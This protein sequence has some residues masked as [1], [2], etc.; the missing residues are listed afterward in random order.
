MDAKITRQ[1]NFER[2]VE[3]DVPESELTPHFDKAYQKYKK[4][5][6]LEGFRKGK[7]PMG[8]VKQLY[9]DAIKGETIDDVV[10]SVFQEVRIK[11]GLRPVAPAKLE[12][13]DYSPE[14]GLHFK[15]VV[16]VVPEIEL[17]NYTGLSVER[18][19]YQV[20]DK[21]VEQALE[22]YRER[23]ATM[24]PVEGAAA[25]GHF[26]VVD[27]QQVDA[28]GVP[29]IGKKFDDRLIELS[30]REQS[31]EMT[32]QLVG[33]KAGET[34]RVE[35]D[36]Y[37]EK[38][39]KQERVY[40]SA[41]VKEIKSKQLPVLDDELAKDIGGFETLKDLQDDIRTRLV[42]RSDF[43]ANRGLRN[44]LIDEL[45]KK[46]EFELPESMVTNY[47]DAIVEGARKDTSRPFDEDAI[48]TEYRPSAVW[49]LKWQLAKD[50]LLELESISINDD[51]KNQMIARLAEQQ[52]VDEKEIKKSLRG[53]Q[54][55]SRFDDDVLEGKTLDFL[56]ERAK[57]KEKKL[58]RK[59]LEKAGKLAF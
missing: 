46:N 57:V 17:K 23:M 27:F 39:N 43:N 56:Q 35:L 6:K 53:K 4:N 47:L 2:V 36:S 28:S 54:A 45:L 41:D 31:A 20:D 34:R 13:V 1:G 44:R 37:D 58:T 52:G 22:E 55:Q 29:I 3:V 25:E 10:Q 24:E 32:Q 21:D 30:N 49:T 11:E 14:N 16:E 5:I 50:R 19:T 59:D 12:D 42:N 18:E 9:G 15:A 7:V 38:G 33:V 51:D 8:L 40:Y 48:R 26:I